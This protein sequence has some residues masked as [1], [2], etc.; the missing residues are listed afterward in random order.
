MEVQ[1]IIKAVKLALGGAG[2]FG[3]RYIEALQ[4]MPGVELS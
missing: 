2:A 3:T 1:S 4:T